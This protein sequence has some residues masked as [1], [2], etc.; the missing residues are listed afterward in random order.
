M[1]TDVRKQRV[2][3]SR[4]EKWASEVAFNANEQLQKCAEWEKNK[5]CC[6]GSNLQFSSQSVSP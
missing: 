3:R 1:H 6:Q 5:K 2:K 4:R